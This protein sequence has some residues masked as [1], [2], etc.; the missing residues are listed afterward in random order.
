[1]HQYIPYRQGLAKFPR[2]YVVSRCFQQ[3]TGAEFLLLSGVFRRS[4]IAACKKDL[5]KNPSPSRDRPWRTLLQHTMGQQGSLPTLQRSFKLIPISQPFYCLDY[6]KTYFEQ[7]YPM[8][9]NTS[10]L[11]YIQ[12]NTRDTLQNVHTLS[13]SKSTN[14]LTGQESTNPHE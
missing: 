7:Q 13:T 12:S 10:I 3:S 6:S 8:T 14:S 9:S 4:S 5:T 2:C 1:M 11:H